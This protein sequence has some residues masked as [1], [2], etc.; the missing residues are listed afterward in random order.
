MAARKTV[1]IGCA[2]AVASVGALYA[3]NGRIAR[4]ETE[5]KCKNR[6][7]GSNMNTDWFYHDPDTNETITQNEG[8]MK[9]S[10]AEWKKSHATTKHEE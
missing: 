3:M 10:R 1:A 8:D 2:G 9:A 6:H 7:K 5:S 4:L